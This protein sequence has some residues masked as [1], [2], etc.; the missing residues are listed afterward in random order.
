[1]VD[2]F[3]ANDIF[4]QLSILAY[5]LSIRIRIKVKNWWRQ[6]YNTFREWFVL[7]PGEIVKKGRQLYLNIYEHYYYKEQWEKFD[8]VLNQ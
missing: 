8:V 7:I 2:D 5:N 4:W 3:W 6:E 1:M